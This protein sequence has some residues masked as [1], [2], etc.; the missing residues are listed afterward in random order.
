MAGGPEFLVN[1]SLGRFDVARMLRNRGHVA[2][3]LFDVYGAREQEMPDTDFLRDAGDNNW[4]VLTG[5]KSMRRRPLE[6]VAILET[7]AKVFALS[8]NQLRSHDQVARIEQ[9]LDRIVRCHHRAGPLF[10]VLY[11]STMELRR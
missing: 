7:G 9:H 2:R 1:R 8:S 3:T 6:R 11:P 10:Y 4:L 5:D